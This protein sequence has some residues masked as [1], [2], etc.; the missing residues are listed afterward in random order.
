MKLI[1]LSLL[2]VAAFTMLSGC[3][4]ES[5]GYYTQSQV[6]AQNEGYDPTART[7]SATRY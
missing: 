1:A 7:Y 4:S 5:E 6:A 3:A 2:A